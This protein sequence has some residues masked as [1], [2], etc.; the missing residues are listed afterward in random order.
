MGAGANALKLHYRDNDGPIRDGD[1]ILVD[2]GAKLD[3]YCAD[4]TRSYPAN[5]RFTGR[6]RELYQAVLT[7]QQAAIEATRPGVTLGELHTAAWNEIDRA[8]HGESFIHGIGHHLGI[9]THDAGEIHQPLR[10]G[11]VITIE[12]GIYLPEEGIGIRIEDD[13]LVTGNG[14]RVLTEAIPKS[15]EA[16][17]AGM[18]R[19]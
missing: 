6:Q 7:A 17:E 9:E 18:A 11:A 10:D 16:I 13:V 3:G 1:L 4:V 14:S 5:G 19:R 15:I 12:P 8:G 2:S